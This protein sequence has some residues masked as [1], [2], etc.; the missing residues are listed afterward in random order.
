V[1]FSRTGT[2]TNNTDYANIGFSVTIPAG[3]ASAT[4][5][6]T[7]VDDTV[8]EGPETVII[9]ISANSNFLVGASGTATVTITD[10][11]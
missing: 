8:V 6:I 1:N 4:V 3:V 7:P 11:D 5:T 10:N 9:T 2:A